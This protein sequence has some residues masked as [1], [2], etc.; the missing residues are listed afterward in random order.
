VPQPH[1]RER[2][3]TR[4]ERRRAAI[5]AKWEARANAALWFAGVFLIGM[6]IGLAAIAFI[7]RA[8]VWVMLT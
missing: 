2:M 3:S 8:A 5:K 4:L 7:W 1:R 6:P